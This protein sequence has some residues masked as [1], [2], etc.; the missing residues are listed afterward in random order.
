MYWFFFGLSAPAKLHKSR[1]FYL[2]IFTEIY[3][4]PHFEPQTF[5][6]SAVVNISLRV[7]EVPHTQHVQSQTYISSHLFLLSKNWSSFT[8]P[9]FY[10]WQHSTSTC[11]G[12]DFLLF[13]PTWLIL[14]SH[15]VCPLIPLESPH[16]YPAPALSQSQF[17]PLLSLIHWPLSVGLLPAIESLLLTAPNAHFLFKS[18]LPQGSLFDKVRSLLQ[19]CIVLCT[20]LQSSYH[21]W[22]F[23]FMCLTNACFPGDNS[24]L[25]KGRN[26]LFMFVFLAFDTFP[27]FT[28]FVCFECMK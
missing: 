28:E 15:W 21:D 3:R 19:M 23:T 4:E 13:T 22:N 27:T 14:K 17:S 10:D 25:R 9:C 2:Y 26:I 16:F 8:G 12:Q 20:S 24:K 7:S 6:S 1:G 18:C 11:I 5:V